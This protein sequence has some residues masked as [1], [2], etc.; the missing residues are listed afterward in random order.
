MKTTIIL[1]TTLSILFF[2]PV[3]AEDLDTSDLPEIQRIES[4]STWNI[5]IGRLNAE[6]DRLTEKWYT[7]NDYDLSESE[8]DI[9]ASAVLPPD[10]LNL[11]NTEVREYLIGRSYIVDELEKYA[12]GLENNLER[13][14]FF[15]NAVWYANELVYAD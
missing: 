10:G 14:I 2:V 13:A 15:H 3:F 5:L 1:L 9:I 7:S 11:S 6:F 8:I 4:T 12:T